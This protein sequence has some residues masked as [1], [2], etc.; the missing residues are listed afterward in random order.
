[1]PCI[2]TTPELLHRN[3]SG[4]YVHHPDPHNTWLR[5]QDASSLRPADV[6]HRPRDMYPSS[7]GVSAPFRV[8]KI[9]SQQIFEII[10]TSPPR[11][12]ISVIDHLI[13]T[14][15]SS[16]N[17]DRLQCQCAFLNFPIVYRTSHASAWQLSL[18]NCGS[19]LGCNVHCTALGMLARHD[20]TLG[21]LSDGI[22]RLARS[23]STG[24]ASKLQ[25]EPAKIRAGSLCSTTASVFAGVRSSGRNRGRNVRYLARTTHLYTRRHAH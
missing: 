1:M 19:P 15:A 10:Y 14:S 18:M 4:E 17:D 2:I 23:W 5:Y 11:R 22:P 9:N 16:P 24:L 13:C 7:L 25:R 3:L 12:E 20:G 6:R 21:I 8:S